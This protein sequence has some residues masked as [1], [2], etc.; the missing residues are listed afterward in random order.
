MTSHARVPK[1][2]APNLV[3]FLKLR[4]NFVNPYIFDYGCVL[5]QQDDELL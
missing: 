2:A 1:K 3:T 4:G 5:Q